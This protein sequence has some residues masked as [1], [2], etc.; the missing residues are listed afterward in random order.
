MKILFCDSEEEREQGISA[1]FQGHEV[2]YEKGH[3]GE[4]ETNLD[5]EV[6]SAFVT[7]KLSR[8]ILAK[9]PK[10]KLI[11]TRSTGFD[12]I[13]LEVCK[14]RGIAVASVPAY[15]EKTVA[16]YAF[17]LLLS[18]S[19][20]VYDGVYRVKHH[21]KFSSEGLMGFD[22][23]DKTLGI[24]GTGKIGCNV[25]MIG[26]GFGMKLL[27]YDVKENE[28]LKKSCSLSYVSLQELI[29]RSDVISL[30][31]PYL[32]ATH[33]MINKENLA[34]VKKGAVL[35][36][37]A[38]GAL[39]ETEALLEALRDGRLAGA[40][41]DVLEEE[42]YIG[43]ESSLISEDHPKKE[44]MND[45]LADHELIGMP[46]VLVTPHNAFNSREA[47]DRIWQT[48]LEN[49]KAFY[50]GGPQNLVSMK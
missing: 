22:L 32:P 50:S 37:T 3:A 1:F 7:S 21:G 15:G 23:A 34:K 39:V 17:A 42:G 35:I 44:Q 47:V 38:R 33:H 31:A 48:T 28:D 26:Q 6:I 43:E 2:V 24:V 27:A 19:R 25:A 12:H 29:E 10:L 8:D 20:K 30:H 40:A 5:A 4:V 45:V 9:F 36:N 18:L 46:N 11:A 16:E 14:E 49:I 13:D 41:L